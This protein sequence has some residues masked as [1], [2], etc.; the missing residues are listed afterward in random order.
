MGSRLPQGAVPPVADELARHIDGHRCRQDVDDAVLIRGAA[1]PVGRQSRGWPPPQLPAP[2]G[3]QTGAVSARAERTELIGGP[4]D[5]FERRHHRRTV[6]LAAPVLT[7][8]YALDVTGPQRPA[9]MQQPP[10]DHAAVT[11]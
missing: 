5:P 8:R 10:L 4:Y 3:V 6:P 11:H 7:D 1:D 2:P 9:G